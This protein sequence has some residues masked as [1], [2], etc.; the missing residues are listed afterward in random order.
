MYFKKKEVCD[1]AGELLQETIKDFPDEEI[2][3]QV[4]EMRRKKKKK[5]RN[6]LKT[7]S[8]TL[9]PLSNKSPKANS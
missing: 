6:E 2:T 4:R 8:N 5:G 3:A 9:S 7:T 1:L